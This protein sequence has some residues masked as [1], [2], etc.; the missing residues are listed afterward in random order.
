MPSSQFLRLFEFIILPFHTMAFLSV[1]MHY[2]GGGIVYLLPPQINV[3]I[4]FHGFCWI[5]DSSLF[6]TCFIHPYVLSKVDISNPSEASCS[7]NW[8]LQQLLW[9][10]KNGKWHEKKHP[11]LSL[12][13]KIFKLF[14]VEA[15]TIFFCTYSLSLK[16]GL[17]LRLPNA[18]AS[19]SSRL[20]VSVPTHCSG[21]PPML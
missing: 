5:A 12:H 2:L 7:W 4:E 17:K 13:L 15:C 21:V 6:K 11:F 10:S 14:K 9:A 1:H 19:S 18:V 16:A 8:N 20:E 3:Y